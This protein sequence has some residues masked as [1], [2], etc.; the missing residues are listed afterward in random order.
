[1]EKEEKRLLR[2]YIANKKKTYTK[3]K[4]LEYSLS[5]LD[6]LEKHPVFIQAD[7]ILLYYSL[8]DEVQTHEF[9]DKW[10]KNKHIILPVVKGEELDAIRISKIYRKEVTALKNRK[11]KYLRIMKISIWPLYPE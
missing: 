11:A 6:S 8:P 9:V 5:L 7:T 4:L 3:D 10:S 1:M 2:R